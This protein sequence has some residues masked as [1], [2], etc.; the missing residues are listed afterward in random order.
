MEAVVL[1]YFDGSILVS[2]VQAGAT[3]DGSG[4][5]IISEYV[6][7]FDTPSNTDHE[8]RCI[9]L[10][11]GRAV[12]G[13]SGYYPWGYYATAVALLDIASGW[14]ANLTDTTQQG[15]RMAMTELTDGSGILF[16][17]D[18]R[19]YRWTFGAGS[20]DVLAD[21]GAVDTQWITL[22]QDGTGWV[23]ADDPG[24]ITVHDLSNAVIAT[25]TPSEAIRFVSGKHLTQLSAEKTN[26]DGGFYNCLT[27]TFTTFYTDNAGNKWNRTLN[28]DDAGTTFMVFDGFDTLLYRVEGGVIK[29]SYPIDPSMLPVNY[30]SAACRGTG[31]VIYSEYEDG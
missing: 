22:L 19:I 21:F 12:F 7:P 15:D 23:K 5:N 17:T 29:Y 24:T 13:I 8:L 10:R 25:Y 18:N 14:V 31:A 4:M 3:I 30:Y 9:P 16:N 2:T 6:L 26:M 20:F 27:D 1:E 11:D 28:E